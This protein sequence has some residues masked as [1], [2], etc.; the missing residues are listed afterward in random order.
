LTAEQCLV[1]FGGIF[2]LVGLLLALGA[3]VLTDR[4]LGRTA[5]GEAVLAGDPGSEYTRQKEARKRTRDRLLYTGLVLTAL[6][7]ALQT[8]AA[9]V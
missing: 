9:F 3:E 2:L 8:Y 7:V 6:G 4:L 5:L 1:L